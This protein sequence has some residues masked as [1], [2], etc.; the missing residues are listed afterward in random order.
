MQF[1]PTEIKKL[2]VFVFEHIQPPLPR[3]DYSCMTNP[4]QPIRI[5]A[6]C[7]RRDFAVFI[8]SFYLICTPCGLFAGFM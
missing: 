2:K 4:S 3:Y 5:P 6:R 1:K 8:L 7:F